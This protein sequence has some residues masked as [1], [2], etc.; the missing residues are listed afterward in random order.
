MCI[1]SIIENILSFIVI[2]LLIFFTF[3]ELYKR[4]NQNIDNYEKNYFWLF[5][6]DFSSFEHCS[7]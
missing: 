6:D 2:E 5:H 7:N 4:V 1:L 3:G